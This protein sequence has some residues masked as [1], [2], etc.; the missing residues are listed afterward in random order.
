[1][2][3]VASSTLHTSRSSNTHGGGILGLRTLSTTN[4]RGDRGLVAWSEE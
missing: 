3:T 1:V 2:D 4:T